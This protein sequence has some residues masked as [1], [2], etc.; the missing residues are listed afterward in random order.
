MLILKQ[1][2]PSKLMI[3]GQFGFLASI[4]IERSLSW[5]T[6]WFSCDQAVAA[7]LSE[8]TAVWEALQF[9]SNDR[10]DPTATRLL[11]KTKSFSFIMNN[12]YVLNSAVPYLSALSKL[13]QTS[14]L[15]FA[16]IKPAIEL[17]KSEIMAVIEESIVWKRIEQ[18][19]QR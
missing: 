2:F 5:K 19:W 18:D 14:D 4:P 15:N 7:A 17:C 1:T 8:I 16:Q 10:S 3:A 9:F 11:R 12:L 13:F 6:R